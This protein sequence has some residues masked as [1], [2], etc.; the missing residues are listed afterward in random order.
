[1]KY[2]IKLLTKEECI[3]YVQNYKDKIDLDEIARYKIMDYTKYKK[4]NDEYHIYKN[5]I[6]YVFYGTEMVYIPHIAIIKWIVDKTIG[7]TIP[8]FDINGVIV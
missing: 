1:M 5:E 7:E 6:F 3:D 4:V 2:N 8:K